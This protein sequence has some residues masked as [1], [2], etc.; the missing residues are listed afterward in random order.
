MR[1]GAA[2]LQ[3]GIRGPLIPAWSK[4]QTRASITH[5]M[6]SWLKSSSLPAVFLS[7]LALGTLWMCF[8]LAT[9]RHTGI[10]K[11]LTQARQFLIT[12]FRSGAAHQSDAVRSNSQHTVTLKWNASTTA[13]VRY[14]VYRRGISGTVKVNPSPLTATI[15]VDSAIQ[16]GQTYY[17]VAKAVNAKGTESLAS[18]E[19]Q[20]TIPS[21]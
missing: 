14:N 21:P 7:V 8:L 17:Y 4:L 13:G 10:L 19:V 15:C 1:K 9:H 11:T 20:V 16:P 6:K 3:G 12:G 5:C 18:N 2:Y